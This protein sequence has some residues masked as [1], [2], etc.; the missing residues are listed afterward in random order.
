MASSKFEST[1]GGNWNANA[2]SAAALGRDQQTPDRADGQRRDGP[3]NTSAKLLNPFGREAEFAGAVFWS[4]GG[5]PVC[6]IELPR[7]AKTCH[8]QVQEILKKSHHHSITPIGASND[9]GAAV[10][11]S[12]RPRLVKD[13]PS[14]FC[15]RRA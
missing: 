1:G 14:I 3:L 4:A 8:G 12:S 6:D 2:S 13:H 7:A 10:R 9:G 5:L 15:G 11:C